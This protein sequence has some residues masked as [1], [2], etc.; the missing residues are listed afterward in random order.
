MEKSPKI[1]DTHLDPQQYKYFFDN[2]YDLLCIANTQGYFEV[3]NP[4]WVNV[5]G[6]PEV[7]LLENPFF[8]FIHPDDIDSTQKELEKL[9]TGSTTI[10]FVNR[11]RK[12]DGSYLWFE[13]ST[14]P[15]HTTGKL[16]AIARD[17]TERRQAEVNLRAIKADL[18]AL[19]NHL[20]KQNNQLLHFA[21]ITSHNLR[22]PVSNLTSLLQFYKESTED[23][24]KKALLSKLEAV[25]VHLNSTLN[26][27]IEAL[28]IQQDL[29]KHRE[30]IS[31]EEIFNLMKDTFIGH[32]LETKA[33]VSADFSKADRIE[34]P[35][36]YLESI[37]LNLLS[38]SIKYRSPNR[39]PKVHFET[40]KIN[41]KI[42]LTVRDNGLG[43]DLE[44]H[45]GNLF[46]LNKTFHTHSEAKGVGLYLTKTQVEA[47][48]GTISAESEVGS[49]TTFKIVF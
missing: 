39:P 5:L 6:Y 37:M 13:W 12:K 18:E 36:S 40:C 21:Y 22:S 10:N 14:T 35:S 41:D 1:S 29:S 46:G 17:I 31:F 15:D 30:L 49:G 43:I 26:E 27:L 9:K 8:H 20:Q 48:G 45:A 42:I 44:K 19:T 33:I 34:Y 16:F 24:E 4:N 11:Y 23:E 2:S 28:K 7:E 47:M 25:I 38:N 32:I 3:L